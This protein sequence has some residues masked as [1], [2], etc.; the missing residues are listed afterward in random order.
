M[1]NV[2][3]S[4]VY[5]KQRKVVAL[6]TEYENMTNMILQ[7]YTMNLSNVHGIKQNLLYPN[8]YKDS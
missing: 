8:E 3:S 5:G 2:S 1:V 7:I 4:H 6:L